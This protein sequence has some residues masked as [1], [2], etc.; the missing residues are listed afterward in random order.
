MP[1]Y[2]I[3]PG[4]DA[5]FQWDVYYTLVWG[6][7]S[8]LRFGL[9]VTALTA[10]IGITVGVISGYVGGLSNLLA[11][12]V[13]DAFLAFPV[14]AG[15]WVIQRAFYGNIYNPFSDQRCNA[16]SRRLSGTCGPCAPSSLPCSPLSPPRPRSC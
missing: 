9:V 15:V 4:Q 16:T 14:I 7:R 11:M 1:Q 13:T 3:A 8:A 5:S 10:L 12:R 6:A 2:G